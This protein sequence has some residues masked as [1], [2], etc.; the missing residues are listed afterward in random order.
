MTQQ[1]LAVAA[2]LSVSFVGKLEAGKVDPTWSTVIRLARALGVGVAAFDE[3][4]PEEKPTKGK[5]RHDSLSLREG[6]GRCRP[7]A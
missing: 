7:V 4:G 6:K 1:G 2:G 5:G 3:D